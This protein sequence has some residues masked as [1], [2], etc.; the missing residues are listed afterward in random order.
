M[1][2]SLKSAFAASDVV[3]SPGRAELDVTCE[4]S[5]KTYFKEIKSIDLLVCNAGATFDEILIK[6]DQRQWDEAMAVN[7]KGAF[8]CAKAAIPAMLRAGSGHIVFVSS[9]SAFSP[10]VGQAN[11]AAAKAG[12]VGLAKSLAAEL[13]SRAIRVNTVVPGWLE[14]RM[15]ENVLEERVDEVKATHALG[16]FNTPE[17]VASFIETLHRRMPFTSGQVFHL[18]SRIL[19]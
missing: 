8:L 11:Y 17:A 19:P 6:M 3:Y 9:Y 1:A 16:Q 15:T 7:L 5:V 18:D 13:G 4:E 14:T 10:P 12:L 2:G